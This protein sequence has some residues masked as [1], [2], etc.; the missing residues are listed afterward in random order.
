MSC[1]NARIDTD[2][3]GGTVSDHLYLAHA[4]LVPA[5]ES[6]AGALSG[7]GGMAGS[8]L[9]SEGWAS[10]YDPAAGRLLTGAADL[11]SGA[12]VLAN[13][14]NATFRNHAAADGGAVVRLEPGEPGG[15]VN[16]EYADGDPDP[17]HNTTLLSPG[18]PPGTRG[19]NGG[20]PDVWAKLQAAPGVV[21]ALVWPDADTGRLRDT[22]AAWHRA[23]SALESAARYPELA[24][25]DLTGLRSPEIPM[26]EQAFGRMRDDC[27]GLSAA[28]GKMGQACTDY[29][30]AV[31]SIRDEILHALRDLERDSVINGVASGVLSLV[32]AG[33]GAGVAAEVESA[34]LARVAVR[35]GALLYKLSKLVERAKAVVGPA[36]EAVSAI[37][38]RLPKLRDA[39]VINARFR[40]FA[41]EV[42]PRLQAPEI[43]FRM[44]QLRKKF[45][46]AELFGIGG[47]F[48]KANA[49]R[50][51]AAI[52]DFIDAGDTAVMSGTMRGQPDKVVIYYNTRTHVFVATKL[53]G[54]FI[55]GWE[56]TDL[57]YE[58]LLTRGHI[59]LG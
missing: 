24:R 31:E 21:G 2:H 12:G 40:E 41:T 34:L 58:K 9:G 6:L 44:S 28:M 23:A 47:N 35:V 16:P 7:S 45:D 5:V 26:A 10:D 27:Y 37:L 25:I 29:A 8:G 13:L 19:H 51:S 1:V 4:A 52:R 42:L 18:A 48:N 43:T 49:E 3:G 15:E 32:T 56:L 20:A 59:G 17:A 36:L 50:F 33:G 30:D 11:A 22:A 57:A 46:H 39:V 54:D 14:T 53:D 55:S 38:L